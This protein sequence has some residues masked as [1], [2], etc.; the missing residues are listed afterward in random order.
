MPRMGH[1]P[2]IIVPG[3]PYHVTHRANHR[4][5][6]FQTDQ[7]RATYVTIMLRWQK[8]TGVRIAAFVIMS[9]HVHFVIVAPTE[10]ALSAWI[11]N[12]HREYSLWLN[13]EAGTS[14][15]NWEGRFYSVLMDESHC[16]NALR[17]VE[18]NPVRARLV[19]HPCDWHWSSAAWHAG[20]GPKPEFLNIDL[21]PPS[22]TE[23]S[24]R[25]FL[26][27]TQDETFGIA[28]RECQGTGKPFA[29]EAWLRRKERELEI[30]LVH[31]GKA[32]KAATRRG[33]PPCGQEGGEEP[34][35]ADT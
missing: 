6:I 3:L 31:A 30:T 24:W 27:A 17:Y 11:R 26:E 15:Q 33:A 2:R 12:G 22:T 35:Q 28:L 14:G 23:D 25:Q 21:R 34:P 18:Q 20:R 13:T 5:P 32:R 9:N 10:T 19:A 7:Q 4:S 16:L 1:R 8:R 29:A